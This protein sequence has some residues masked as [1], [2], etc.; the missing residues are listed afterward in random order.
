MKNR[1]HPFKLVV[2]SVLSGLAFSALFVIV[3]G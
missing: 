2:F 1:T 3:T